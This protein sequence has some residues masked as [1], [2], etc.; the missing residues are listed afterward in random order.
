[1]GCSS[2]GIESNAIAD[3]GKAGCSSGGC[4]RFNVYDW[5]ADMPVSFQNQS[6]NVVEVNFKQGVRKAYY[7]NTQGLMLEKGDMVVVDAA[8][9]YDIGE[10]SLTG[11]LVKLQMAKRGIKDRSDTIRNLVRL[12]DVK[13][14]NQLKQAREKEKE[15][16]VRARVIARE[17][18]LDMKLGDIEM[19]G[20]LK[21]ATFF[22]TA[23]DRVDFR[24]LVKL[25]ARDFKVK[26][27]MRQ[28]G[29]RQEAARIGG[30]GSC[31][32]ELCCSTWLNDFKSVNTNAARYQNLSINTDKLS[33][34]CGRL[35]CCLNYELDQY[36][37]A[38]MSMPKDL[39]NLK[40][41]A[42]V[43]KVIKTEVLS[44]RY[45]LKYEESDR[46]YVINADEAKDMLH[47]IKKGDLPE[48][49]SGY[50]RQIETT[51]EKEIN[52]DL[53]GHVSLESLE[54]HHKRK[55][56]GNKSGGNR[57]QGRNRNQQR[58]K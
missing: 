28:I 38:V 54:K 11:E 56:R 42:G 50:E 6:F 31:G 36:T 35:K 9:G 39:R 17:Q 32:R 14:L 30:I 5:F 44:R 18:K 22:Y 1:M 43:A 7:R 19:Q 20:D 24:E 16:L 27:E 13:D 12:A 41:K 58:R 8:Q 10:V 33:G 52:E 57:Q 45:W 21:K 46:I 4:N 15:I 49:L 40:T 29:A 53:V 2:C 25:Y 48:G 26:I 34:Q 51:I 55:K 37:E 3:K 23:D 47:A